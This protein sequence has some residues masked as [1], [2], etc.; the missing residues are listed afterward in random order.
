MKNLIIKRVIHIQPSFT[1]DEWGLYTSTY[2]VECH[3]VA[4]HLNQ[5]LREYVNRGETREEVERFLGYA[6]RDSAMYGACD[7]E[8]FQF[9]QRVL[10]TIF[11]QE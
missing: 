7:A 10:V 1:A 9:L 11:S 6:M 3:V 5:V 8:A 4:Q 2:P